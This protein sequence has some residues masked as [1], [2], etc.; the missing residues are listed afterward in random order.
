MQV[1]VIGE[2]VYGVMVGQ[3]I[4]GGEGGKGGGVG[5]W[6][7]VWGVFPFLCFV[8]I[9][10]GKKLG[11]RGR[12]GMLVGMFPAGGFTCHPCRCSV[13]EYLLNLSNS[14]ESMQMQMHMALPVLSWF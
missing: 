11:L 7:G 8:F 14:R 6:W 4:G 5:R 12:V 3:G 2:K 13:G 9:S 10:L 1:Y